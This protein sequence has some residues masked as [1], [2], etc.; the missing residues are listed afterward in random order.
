[1]DTL[2]KLAES[3]TGRELQGREEERRPTTRCVSN[4][5]LSQLPGVSLSVMGQS[6]SA[7]PQAPH[8]QAVPP[9]YKGLDVVDIIPNEGMVGRIAETGGIRPLSPPSRQLLEGCIRRSFTDVSQVK[10][11]LRQGADP[12]SCGGLRVHGTILTPPWQYSCLTLAIDSPLSRPSLVNDP[13][14]DNADGSAVRFPPVVLPQWSSRQL[15][16]DIIN[17]L[18]DGGADVNAAEGL[19]GRVAD[20]P[21]RVAVAAGNL[22]AVQT[23]LAGNPNV[24]G[25]AVMR[26][27]FLPYGDL[28]LTREYE[29]AVM[30]II[31]RLIQHDSTLATELFFGDNL[32]HLAARSPSAFSQ[33]F[34]DQYLDLITSHGAEMTANGRVHGTPLHMAAAHGSPYVADWLCR[35]LTAED[36]NRGS[37]N[38]PGI[39][40]LSEAAEGLDRLIQHQQQL[41]QYGE[42]QVE[43][44]SR[45][46]RHHKTITWT[47]LRGGAAPSISR[48]PNDTQ[49]YRRQRQVVLTEYA[50]VL[51]ELSE[52]VILAINAALAP[53]RDH[54]MLLARLLPLA[55]HHDGA[56]PHPSPSNMAFGPHEAE[57]IAWRIGAFLH[58]PSAAS[59]AID[60]YLIGDSLLRRRIRAAVGHFVKSAATQTSSNREV[61]GGVA[62]VGGVMVRVPL[63]CFALRGSGSRVVLT[64]VREVIH[65][66]RL[67]EAAQHGVVGVVKGFNEHLGDLD[68]QFEWGVC[69]GPDCLCRWASTERERALV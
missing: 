65:R 12:R 58:E 33:Q 60:E 67:D 5:V 15:Q 47:L 29:D 44:W 8:T 34:I 10:Q 17:A 25:F 32:V 52:V 22:A 45:R 2:S 53:Q 43:R 46:F 59:A 42:G 13:F 6:P 55:P 54:S 39:T 18:I 19:F 50:T 66:A 37:P 26:V 3:E 38:H 20:R 21:I 41:Q 48:M 4:I 36:I 51:N 49:Q 69:P 28:S 31:R 30:C 9:D 23:L 40:P 64:G 14:I 7:A 63:Q 57:A 16:C 68:C 24:R 62:S 61:V 11:L 35:R 27:P 1:M 56:H